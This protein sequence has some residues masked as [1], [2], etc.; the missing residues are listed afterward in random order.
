M[1]GVVVD[2]LHL[3]ILTQNFG[4]ENLLQLRNLHQLTLRRPHCVDCCIGERGEGGTAPGWFQLGS[5]RLAVSWSHTFVDQGGQFVLKERV[6]PLQQHRLGP[7][8]LAAAVSA[9]RWIGVA[10]VPAGAGRGVVT[11]TGSAL[12]TRSLFK[13]VLHSDL[14]VLV[15]QLRHCTTKSTDIVFLTGLCKVATV[16]TTT[17]TTNK[18]Q[19]PKK[20]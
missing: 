1:D 16:T 3:F 19:Q 18:Q 8:C 13:Q 15:K 2:R 11:C 12:K 20:K 5:R 17:T 9:T 7:G 6:F 14:R 10:S 4:G